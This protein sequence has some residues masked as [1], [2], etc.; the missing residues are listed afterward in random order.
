M[1]RIL[2]RVSAATLVVTGPTRKASQ[3]HACSLGPGAVMCTARDAAEPRASFLSYGVTASA[4]GDS[5][6]CSYLE[7]PVEDGEC[8]GQRSGQGSGRTPDPTLGG[9]V[10]SPPG[11][12]SSR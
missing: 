11:C 2:V 7:F 6:P 8:L 12:H 10:W 4:A 3:S 1:P 5:W 9:A